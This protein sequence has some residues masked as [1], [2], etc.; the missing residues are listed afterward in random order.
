MR[1]TWMALWLG[2]PIVVLQACSKPQSD[3]VPITKATTPAASSPDATKMLPPLAGLNLT[4]IELGEG[5]ATAPLLGEKTAHLTVDPKLQNTAKALMRMHH[6]P[7]AA[8]VLM[9]TATGN[10]LVYASHIEKGPARDLCA[11][12][13]APAASVFKIV[14]SAAL[15]ENAGLSPDERT[16]YSGGEQRI[17]ERDLIDDPKKDK[18]CTTLGGAMGRSINTVFA[19]F[20]RKYL[21]APILAETAH[22]FGFGAPLAFD[23][24]VEPSELHVPEDPLGFARMAA[25]F[26]NTTLSPLHAAWISATVARGGE[27]VRPRI[28]REVADASGAIVW[29]APEPAA[30][31]RAIKPKTAQSIATMMENTI[32]DGTSYKAFHD[33]AG[34]SFLADIPMAGKTGTLTDATAQRFYTWFS[35]FSHAPASSNKESAPT[36]VAIGV[37]VVNGPTWTVKA[38]VVA[39]EVLRAYFAEHEVA[40][41]TMPHL[42]SSKPPIAKKKKRRSP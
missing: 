33:A 36:P 16:C 10:V 1:G 38:N 19:R 15:V 14:T 4:R 18:W 5:G 8:V 40:G 24:P 23:V 27:P 17:T 30:L 2:V 3:A 11:E 25:G 31:E 26:W 28:V 6:V 29:T 35:G 7:E 39:R 37:L 13:T 41:I 42:R 9:D 21:K 22:S 20:A 32:T 12:A 34:R